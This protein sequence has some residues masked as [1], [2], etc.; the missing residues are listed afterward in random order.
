MSKATQKQQS[1]LLE[2]YQ[3]RRIRRKIRT[4]WNSTHIQHYMYLQRWA[5]I[6]KWTTCWYES[7]T[8]STRSWVR[9]SWWEPIRIQPLC[10][11]IQWSSREMDSG[12]KGKAAE[13]IEIYKRRGLWPDKALR[14]R[15]IIHGLQSCFNSF[16]ERNTETP[17]IIISTY[18]K[19]VRNWPKLK[20]G[21]AKGFRKFYNFLLKCEGLAK[22]QLWNVINSPDILYMLVSKLP[23]GLI[24]RWNRTTHNVRKR[25]DCEPSLGDLIEFV[26]QETTLVN[27]PMFSRET[28]EYYSERLKKPNDKRNR[29]V[30]SLV[31]E[32]KIGGCPFCSAR[33]DI[34]ECNEFKKLPVNERSKVF[35]K[36]KLC[37]GCCQLIG[38]GHNSKT[39]TKRRKCRGCY[40]K[41]EQYC[42][43]FNYRKIA[44]GN[45]KK[46]S[47]RKK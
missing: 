43:V 5:I 7:T 44:K 35:F 42:M 40:G 45:Q 19:E 29:R 8:S 25:Q 33:H 11:S 38:D 30:K 41:I 1:I 23:S 6:K 27:D 17:H 15:T 4:S 24:D 22:D 9:M 16:L 26:D 20:F 13:T 46:K 47:G 37:Y 14:A 28:L 39:C 18:K 31:I 21:D 10:S 3:N 2:S 32:T 34:E 12:T 36:I